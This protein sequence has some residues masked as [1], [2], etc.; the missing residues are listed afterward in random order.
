MNRLMI[1]CLLLVALTGCSR[2]SDTASGPVMAEKAAP[3]ADVVAPEERRRTLAYE[4]H[5]QVEVPEEKIVATHEAALAACR[6]ASAE[7]CEVLESRI[8]TGQYASASLRARAKPKG[9]Q[10]LIATMGQQGEIASQST[11][12]EDLARPLLDGEKKL[13]MLTSYRAELEALRKRP[14]NDADA[15]I[16]LTRE[17]A[18]VQGELESAT[19]KQ[20]NLMRRV[21]T[22]VLTI[23]I[24]PKRSKSFWGPISAAMS[25]FGASLSQGISSAIT[26]VAYLLPWSLVI[27]LVFWIGRKLWRRRKTG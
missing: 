6:K 13:A 20:A 18:Q 2:R 4:H 14:G 27:G 22:E 9:I 26:G 15:L 8:S 12:A 21:E 11:Q 23:L 10:Q 17:L 24:Q 3:V 7:L 1:A 5:I 25:D 19:D 16:K